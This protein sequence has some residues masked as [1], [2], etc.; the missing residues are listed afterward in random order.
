MLELRLLHTHTHTSNVCTAV[1]CADTKLTAVR[2]L[3]L[4][5]TLCVFI[6]QDEGK[7]GARGRL[8]DKKNPNQN[9]QFKSV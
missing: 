6:R 4:A 8:G 9:H 3:T 1:A 5:S 2:R 7:T